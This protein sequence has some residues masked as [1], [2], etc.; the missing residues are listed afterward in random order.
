L[1]VLCPFV[2]CLLALPRIYWSNFA[3]LNGKAI[4]LYSV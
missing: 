1:Y 4:A 3:I 2:T